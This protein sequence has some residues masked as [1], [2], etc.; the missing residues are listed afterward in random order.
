M[1]IVRP[2]SR[3]SEPVR[4]RSLWVCRYAAGSIPI[5]SEYTVVLPRL[6]VIGTAVCCDATAMSGR[7][8]IA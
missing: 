8:C 5:A 3:S 6:T 1:A 7:R 4:G 2:V